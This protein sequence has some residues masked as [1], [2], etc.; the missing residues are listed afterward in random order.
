MNVLG[1]DLSITATGIAYP[2]GALDTLRPQAAGDHRLDEIANAVGDAAEDTDVV[3]IE[4]PVSNVRS[5]GTNV[6]LGMVHGVV[7]RELIRRGIPY[8]IVPPTVLKKYA[9]GRGTATKADMRVALIKRADID[10]RD[11]NRVD[12]WWLRAAALDAYNTPLIDM[13]K[14]NRDALNSVEWPGLPDQDAA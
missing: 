12:A 3:V 14:T 4:G 8:A 7:R 5:P 10:E 6:I 2:D 11:D 13:P 1:L 9:T